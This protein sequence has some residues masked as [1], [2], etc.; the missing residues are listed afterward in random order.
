M[1]Q[2]RPPFG[3]RMPNDLHEWVKE[4]AEEQGRSMNNFVVTT[5]QS[6]RAEE[7]TAQK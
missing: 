5:L 1:K 3:L 7:A 4:K 6:V 2:K